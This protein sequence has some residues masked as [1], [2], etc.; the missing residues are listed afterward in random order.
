VAAGDA[1]P[2]APRPAFRVTAGG[3][4]RSR[5]GPFVSQCGR[6][7][8]RA[9]VPRAEG[10][11]RFLFRA[12]RPSHTASGFSVLCGGDAY[13]GQPQNKMALLRKVSSRRFLDPEPSFVRLVARP[14]AEN[15]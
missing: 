15:R 11:R 12:T 14:L 1:P 10:A 7:G 4:R 8:L 13:G 3:Y 6:L 5:I 2:L 9:A